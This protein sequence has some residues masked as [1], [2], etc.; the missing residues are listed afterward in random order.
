VIT[1]QYREYGRSAEQID[2]QRGRITADPS[3]RRAEPDVP[4]AELPDAV[5]PEAVER[6]QSDRPAVR[7]LYLDA[8]KIA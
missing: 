3:A 2:A 6:A 5:V 8:W 7:V 1:G 4:A